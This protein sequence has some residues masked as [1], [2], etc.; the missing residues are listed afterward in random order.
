MTCVVVTWRPL[1]GVVLSAA[2][3][4]CIVGANWA[5]ARWGIVPIGFGLAA[6]AG[7][8]FAGFSFGLRDALQE[9]SGRSP[10]LALIFLGA[11][12][13]WLIEPQ[14]AV[15]SGVSFLFGELVDFAI[16]NPLRSRR[17]AVAVAASNVAGAVVDS[18]LFLWLAFGTAAGWVDLTIGKAY[19]TLPAMLVVWWSR[20]RQR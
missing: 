2:Y 1:K 9:S 5:I 14:F 13:S 16:Y 8:Y 20:R 19:M 12:L 15:A 7:V 4:G 10:V 3:L 18:L 17:W 6:P 11:W